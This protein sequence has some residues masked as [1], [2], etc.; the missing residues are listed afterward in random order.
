[1]VRLA[2]LFTVPIECPESWLMLRS[3]F[4]Q[5]PFINGAN[6]RVMNCE[7]SG[8]SAGSIRSDQAPGYTH[9]A[10][11]APCQEGQPLEQMDVLLVL[12][13]RAMQW[14]NELLRVALAQNLGSDILD[15][16]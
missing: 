16:Q 3:L 15:Q 11:F 12:E 10:P 4:D 5:H 13:Q 14:R 9:S 7:G 6:V 1:M 2:K 8:T